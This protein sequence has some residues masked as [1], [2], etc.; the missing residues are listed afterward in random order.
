MGTR[1][2]RRITDNRIENAPNSETGVLLRSASD[3]RAFG[4]KHGCYDNLILNVVNLVNNIPD[5]S[6][7]YV[8]MDST[9]SGSL[10]KKDGSWVIQ[11]NR[12]HSE[13]RQRFTIAHELGHFIYHKDDEIDAH[14]FV[15]TTFFRGMTAN[16]LEY[17]ANRFASELLMPEPEVRQLIDTENI[18][19]IAELASKF[20]VS[21]AA[22]LFRVK[23]L[24]Y[25]TKE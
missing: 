2:K 5:V 17:T 18:R 6:L 24:N 25:T 20:G 13:A 22:M 10:S 19:S 8:D 23:E 7:E 11:V 1:G 9:L 14:K 16:N 21:S 4:K 3:L 15:D 12:L